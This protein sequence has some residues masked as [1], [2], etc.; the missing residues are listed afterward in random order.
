MGPV[1][2]CAFLL[3]VALTLFA[4][5]I[6]IPSGGTLGVLSAIATVAALVVA[7]RD[8]PA[9]GLGT[10]ATIAVVGPIV[11]AI[12]A[13]LWPRTPF[14]RRIIQTAPQPDEVLPAH[15]SLDHLVNQY[16]KALSRMLPGGVVEVQ[17]E[18]WDATAIGDLIEAGE[19]VVVMKVEGRRLVVQ[20]VNDMAPPPQLS[21][22][23]DED[24]PGE[25]I[26]SDFLSDLMNEFD[27]RQGS[28]ESQ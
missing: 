7:F 27:D 4:M 14:G 1:Y 26:E 13:K 16:G 12:A 2:W 18:S 8:G 23:D 11:F 21:I 3:L 28:G 15:Q 5:E 19:A 24:S 22:P 10:L 9:L 20:R 25:P 6:F 17:G